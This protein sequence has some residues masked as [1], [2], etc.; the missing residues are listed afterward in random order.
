[1]T[2]NDGDDDSRR[3]ITPLF[4]R[5]G[6]ADVVTG[7][8]SGLVEMNIAGTSVNL[9]HRD[10]FET[11]A[12]G[13]V[14][15][16]WANKVSDGGIAHAAMQKYGDAFNKAYADYLAID[17]N[18]EKLARVVLFKDPEADLYFFHTVTVQTGHLL[19]ARNVAD[20][21]SYV[22]SLCEQRGIKSVG[23][24]AMCTGVQGELTDEQS[25]KTIAHAI[26][27]FSAS[28]P[29]DVKVNVAISGYGSRERF[30]A[31]QKVFQNPDLFKDFDPTAEVGLREEDIRRNI[32]EKSAQGKL[33]VVVVGT[34]G[35]I[36]T[37]KPSSGATLHRLGRPEDN[38]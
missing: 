25:A 37:S 29:S 5:P 22:L 7:D 34:D 9:H 28:K 8:F 19:A 3:V 4:D 35:Q 26:H 18:R 11:G 10:L 33:P 30:I 32:A 1:M 20:A 38:L 13:F 21:V 15:P 14:I 24:P 17:T 12:K 36:I 31:F 23:F 16:Q 6:G 27:Q 2:G